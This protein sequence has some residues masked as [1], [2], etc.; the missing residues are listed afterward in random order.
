MFALIWSVPCFSRKSPPVDF[1]KLS[2]AAFEPAE[3]PP[4]PTAPECRQAAVESAGAAL[5][6]G[7][8]NPRISLVAAFLL[9]A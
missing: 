8:L 1:Q 3:S 7:L 6:V 2:S 4:S 9:T 5:P